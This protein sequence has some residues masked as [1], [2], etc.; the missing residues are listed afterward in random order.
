M[1]ESNRNAFGELFDTFEREV[2]R[3]ETLQVYTVL[4]EAERFAAFRAGQP[5]P[6]LPKAAEDWFRRIADTTLAGKRWYRVHIVDRPLT[7]YVR[8]EFLAYL[9][10]A[11]VGQ[12]T[13]IADRDTHPD[14]AA[15]T[16]DFWPFDD[17]VVVRMQYDDEGH[18]LRCTRAAAE[19]LDEYLHR[20]DVAMQHALPLTDYLSKHGD[21]LTA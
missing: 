16:E 4:A 3:L 8:W 19:D 1:S 21:R 5:L 11:K 9:D 18:F 13:Y 15:L 10:S 17:E 20:R 6:P 12:E 7:D 2:F 14:L